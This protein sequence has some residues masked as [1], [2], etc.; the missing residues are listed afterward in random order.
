MTNIIA[1]IW[2]GNLSPSRALGENDPSVKELEELIRRNKQRLADELKGESVKRFEVYNDGIDEY[3]SAVCEQAF[4]DG[5]SYGAKIVSEAFNN[6]EELT[7]QQ[8]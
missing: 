2:N 5:F 4:C 3:I 1:D 8:L 6:V 7:K